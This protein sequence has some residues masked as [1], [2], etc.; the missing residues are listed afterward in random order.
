MTSKKINELIEHIV[1]YHAEK[2]DRVKT[3]KLTI[4]YN[5]IGAIEMPEDILIPEV[6][7]VMNT[8]KGVKSNVFAC[9]T[10]SKLTFL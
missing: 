9:S 6:G 8:R 7:I 3:Q 10:V 1:V 2:I 4:Y 5:C